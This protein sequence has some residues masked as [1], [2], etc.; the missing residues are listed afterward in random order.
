MMT[1]TREIHL[2][3]RPRGL[4]S[5]EDFALVTLDLPDPAA[6]EAQ[7]RNRWVSVDPYMRGKMREGPTAYPLGA[8]MAGRAVGEVVASNAPGLAVGDI[9][10]SD[11]GWREAYNAP[12]A[13]IEKLDLMGMPANAFLGIAGAT[14]MTAYVGLMR[15]APL[16]AGDVVFVSGAAG[17]VGSVACRIAKLM[18]HTVIGSAG[19]E[20]K[21][22]FLLDALKIDAA[23]DYKAA[24][25]GLAAALRRAAPDGSD[26]YFD[27]VGGEHLEAAIDN[28]RPFGRMALC[29]GISS[30]NL[31]GPAA[32]PRNMMLCIGKGLTL[33][34]YTLGQHMDMKPA[35]LKDVAA[36][37]AQGRLAV[38]ETIVEGLENAPDAFLG[39]FR[40]DNLG[41]MVV[42]VS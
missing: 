23:V 24:Q 8:G 35:F 12:A 26:V 41:K 5:A 19:G 31:E 20:A 18:G 42:R 40:G 21:T 27:N 2:V 37:Y 3:R 28:A 13:A 7:V 16:K 33:R 10:Y 17:A 25:D 38:Q 32:G 9:V 36:W 14:G 11:L 30:Y 22:R 34:G 29:G 4:P 1:T 39:L 15:I 6:G